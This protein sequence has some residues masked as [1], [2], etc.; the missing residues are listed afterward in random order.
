[1][2][3]IISQRIKRM[4]RAIGATE[5]S[6][7]TKFKATVVQTEKVKAVFQD[8][9]GNISDDELSNRVHTAI[10]NINHLKDHLEKWAERNSLNKN[11]VKQT[12]NRSFE[13]K[14]VRDLSNSDKHGYEYPNGSWSKKYPRLI[15]INRVMQLQTQPKKG[16]FV[17]LTT[18]NRGVPK[19]IGDG[20]AR[21]VITG[22]VVDNNNNYIGDLRKIVIR[23]IEAWE[24]VLIDFELIK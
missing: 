4:Y 15:N 24:Q 14:I 21:A 16:S 6:D 5:E 19:K 23:A 22:D 12:Y 7:L 8:F 10:Y 11:K 2:D 20:S 9:R 3:D 17:G 18:D 13:L 1:M